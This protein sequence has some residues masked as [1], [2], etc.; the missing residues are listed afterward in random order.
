MDV[1]SCVNMKG[2]VGKTTTAVNVADVLARRHGLKV[3]I[4]DIDPQFNATQCLLEP[5]EYVKRLGASEHTIVDVF[6]DRPRVIPNPV[7]G[8][9]TRE[10]VELEDISPWSIKA[11][12]DLIPG[13]L[14]LYR[15]EFG[16]GQGREQRL[17]RLLEQYRKQDKY[18]VVIIDTPPTPSAWM[19]AAILASDYY[20]IP[21]RPDPL[22]RTG[23]DLLKGVIERIE[24]NFGHE[25]KCLGVVL[26]MVDERTIVLKQTQEF[27]ASNDNWRNALFTNRLPQRTEIA[28]EQGKQHLILDLNDTGAKSA[29]AGLAREIL[30]R[31]GYE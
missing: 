18:D 12:L 6:D 1:L 29:I 14:E 22:S 10:P 31:L 5:D 13:N 23:I 27:F 25:I 7:K 19:T 9:T 17:K 26:T 3:L 21:V 2:G 24:K 30:E 20:M 4:I 8:S 15:L 16:Q 11:N 28:R